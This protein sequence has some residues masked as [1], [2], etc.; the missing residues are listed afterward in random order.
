MYRYVDGGKRYLPGE[1]TDEL[2][3]FDEAGTSTVYDD[4]PE[5]EELPD[6][7]P[8]PKSPAAR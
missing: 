7:P 4:L 2:K 3:V 6:V 5:G 8:H 1:W